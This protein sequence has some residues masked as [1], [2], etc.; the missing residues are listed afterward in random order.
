MGKFFKIGERISVP[1][2]GLAALLVLT[3][4]MPAAA[5][6]KAEVEQNT[7]TTRQG[8]AKYVFLFIGDGM[9]MAQISSTE[10]YATAR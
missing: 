3:A 9:A 2:M 7:A 1:V 4:V 10:V 5:R 8:Q 6:A